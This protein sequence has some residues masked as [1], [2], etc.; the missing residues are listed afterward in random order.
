MSNLDSYANVAN[1][2]YPE[3]HGNGTEILSAMN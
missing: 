3:V 2:D 1:Q